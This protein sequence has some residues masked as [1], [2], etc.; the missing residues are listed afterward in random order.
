MKAWGHLKNDHQDHLKNDHQDPGHLKSDHLD[1]LKDDP[2][3]PLPGTPHKNCHL[4]GGA[5]IAK[6]SP[7]ESSF[8]SAATAQPNGAWSHSA[9][10]WEKA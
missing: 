5:E 10:P 7:S 9:F 4:H 2:P 8:S 6:A 3:R 1:N